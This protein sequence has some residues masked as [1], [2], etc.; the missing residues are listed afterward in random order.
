MKRLEMKRMFSAWLLFAALV[1]C[2]LFKTFHYHDHELTDRTEISS[3]SE[4]TL[5]V[6]SS[7]DLPNCPICNFFLSP[8]VYVPFVLGVCLWLGRLSFV[9]LTELSVVLRGRLCC[10]LR[11]PPASF[12]SMVA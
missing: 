11:A 8:F 1:P 10:C 2:L 6:P 5:S 7:S 12:E 3:S 4:Q 9:C